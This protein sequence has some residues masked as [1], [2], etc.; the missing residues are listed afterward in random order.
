MA[1]LLPGDYSPIST[2]FT[3]PRGPPIP[4]ISSHCSPLHFPS[5]TTLSLASN[6]SESLA[7]DRGHRHGNWLADDHTVNPAATS[8]SPSLPHAFAHLL[9]LFSFFLAQQNDGKDH[10]GSRRS[11]P[12]LRPHLAVVPEIP[13]PR[14]PARR[15]RPVVPSVV[16]I[17]SPSEPHRSFAV[18]DIPSRRRPPRPPLP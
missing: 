14:R 16:V 10:A 13:R 9:S 6:C 12:P 17:F 7:G 8:W 18:D 11:L 15:L 1:R 4:S 5:L 3:T 2:L